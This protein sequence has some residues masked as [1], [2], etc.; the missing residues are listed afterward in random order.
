MASK[1]WETSYPWLAT[2]A[3]TLPS[4][5][6]T[7]GSVSQ[8]VRCCVMSDRKQYQFKTRTV[9]ALLNGAVGIIHYIR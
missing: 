1:Q 2:L 7:R 5:D 8:Q 6:K 9:L 3:I 4:T